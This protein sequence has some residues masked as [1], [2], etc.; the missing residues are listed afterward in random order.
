MLVGF[1]LICVRE[2]FSSADVLKLKLNK[3]LGLAVS[4]DGKE[5]ENAPRTPPWAQFCLK[6]SYLTKNDAWGSRQYGISLV[7][8]WSKQSDK[9][10]DLVFCFVA[11]VC[12]WP[13]LELELLPYFQ[14]PSMLPSITMYLFASPD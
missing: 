4:D 11:A 5:I 8:S 1:Y 3:L 13:N 6:S 14:L 10:L 2:I 7:P 12:N 9:H